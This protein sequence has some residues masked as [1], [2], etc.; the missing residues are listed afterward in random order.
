MNKVQSQKKSLLTRI[1]LAQVAAC[2]LLAPSAFA[3]TNASDELRGAAN[4]MQTAPV[5]FK[6]LDSNGDNAVDWRELEANYAAALNRVSWDKE[7]VIERFDDNNDQQLNTTE[8]NRFARELAQTTNDAAASS[9]S[10]VVGIDGS[11]SPERIQSSDANSR[12][13]EGTSASAETDIENVQLSD[14]YLD[15]SDV[16]NAQA[17]TRESRTD[18]QASRPI[19]TTAGTQVM[20]T[21]HSTA[22]DLDA[23]DLAGSSRGSEAAL[24]DGSRQA[25]ASKPN[26]GDSQRLN[27]QA[28]ASSQS[29]SQN[30]GRLATTSDVALPAQ[31]IPASEIEDRKVVNR[32]GD[33][34]GEVEEVILGGDGAITGLVVELGGFLDIGDKEVFVDI[35]DLQ[36]ARDSVIWQTDMNEETLKNLPEYKYEAISA[37]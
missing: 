13:Q 3:Q 14:N 23:R 30:A 35:A 29:E 20:P 33:A 18:A 31:G 28:D 34:I 37:R 1:V 16:E 21:G 24:D 4:Q 17:Q 6:R 7:R 12:S 2:G 36:L 26:H 15:N 9:V 19:Q 32:N 11:G 10:N 8:Y 27:R 5:E 25:A 22:N